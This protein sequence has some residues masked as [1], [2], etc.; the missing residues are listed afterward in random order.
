VTTVNHPDPW[1][2]PQLLRIYP[3]LVAVAHDAG[4][5]LA[6]YGSILDPKPDRAGNTLPASDL[7]LIAVPWRPALTQELIDGLCGRCDLTVAGRWFGA[8]CESV[9][10]WYHQ[11]IVDLQVRNHRPQAEHYRYE[12]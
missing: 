8:Y 5:L 3:D 1:S 4:F 9:A 6:V 12:L 10:L 11:Q 2:L 7:D